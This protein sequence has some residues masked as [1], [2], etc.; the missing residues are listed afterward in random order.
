MYVGR[1]VEQ[2]PTEQLFRRPAH[3]YT[4]ALLAAAPLADPARRM[5]AAR[6]AGEPASP[7]APPAGCAFHPRCPHAQPRCAAETPTL[8]ELRGP[9]SQR[10][11]CHFAEA[12]GAPHD[13]S[14]DPAAVGN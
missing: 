14:A 12:L 3:P 9:V 13:P 4:Q 11:A 2:A 1:I 6:V 5:A 8:R 10:V 7:L